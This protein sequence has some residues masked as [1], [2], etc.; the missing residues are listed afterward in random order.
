MINNILRI[1]VDLYVIVFIDDIP[2]YWQSELEHR[3]HL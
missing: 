3:D 1:F 2:V